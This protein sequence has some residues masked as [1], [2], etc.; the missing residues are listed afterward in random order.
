MIF[1]LRVDR[2][3][4]LPYPGL[5][6][7]TTFGDVYAGGEHIGCTLEDEVREILGQPPVKWK[8]YKQTAFGEG[9]YRLGMVDSPHFGPDTLT[10]MKVP[11][12]ED[13]RLHGGV[14]ILDTDGCVLVGSRQDRLNGTLHG[15]KIAQTLGS[16]VVPPVLPILK[17]LAHAALLRGDDCYVQVRNA[18]TW[19]EGY[20][21]PF[22][23]ALI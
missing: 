8:V 5:P 1:V 15:A 21:V 16:I 10:I 18:P 19:Y 11:G 17:G 7:K 20:G 22:P 13:V 23:K 12:Y 2:E 14:S 3:E 9:I 6:N 4:S